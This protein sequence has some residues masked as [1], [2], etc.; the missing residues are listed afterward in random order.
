MK[1]TLDYDKIEKALNEIEL[2]MKRLYKY[3]DENEN[4]MSI[5]ESLQITYEQTKLSARFS[6]LIDEYMKP[7]LEK[8]NNK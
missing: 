5:E 3:I 7:I 2:K 4:T 8:R 6:E 1:S